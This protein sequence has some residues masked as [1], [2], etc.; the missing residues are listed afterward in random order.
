MNPLKERNNKTIRGLVLAYV[1]FADP[2]MSPEAI[3]EE[4]RGDYP[5]L[6]EEMLGRV[7]RVAVA[8]L[9]ALGAELY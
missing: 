2:E 9:K 3:L 6:S 4:L 8:T 1:Q 5:A 7:Q